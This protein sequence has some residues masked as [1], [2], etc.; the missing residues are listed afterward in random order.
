M[1]PF[2]VGSCI[3]EENSAWKVNLLFLE[4]VDIC[5]AARISRATL[6]DLE[7]SLQCFFHELK[8]VYPN[9][10][11]TPKMHFLLMYPRLIKKAGPLV[12]FSCMRFEAKHKYMKRLVTSRN[13]YKNVPLTIA[14]NRQIELA[15]T[16][17]S[18]NLFDRDITIRGGEVRVSSSDISLQFNIPVVS[19][20]SECYRKVKCVTFEGIVYAVDLILCTAVNRDLVP[21][22]VKIEAIFLNESSEII[23]VGNVLRSV[24]YCQHFHAWLVQCISE[25]TICCQNSLIYPHPLSIFTPF[26]T[27]EKYVCPKFSLEMALPNRS[28]K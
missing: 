24:C 23:F 3:E 2:L 18:K 26:G 19:F 7:V 17:C 21:K 6:T 10:K 9:E 14:S 8:T 11:I 12:Q 27:S 1:L 16:I 22:F 28:A 15:A 25:T 5:C 20:P 13:N 4:I